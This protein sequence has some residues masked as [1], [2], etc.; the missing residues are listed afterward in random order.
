MI[1]SN[2]PNEKESIFNLHKKEVIKWSIQNNL[3]SAMA[4]YTEYGVKNYTFKMPKLSDPEWDTIL[5]NVSIIS[6]LQGIPIGMKIYNGYAFTTNTTNNFFTTEDT[7]YYTDNSGSNIYHRIDCP[8][9]GNN[10]ITAHKSYLFE[11]ILDESISPAEWRYIKTT[12]K[13]ERGINYPVDYGKLTACYYCMVN[14]NYTQDSLFPEK[15]RA[16][17]TAI[18]K[19]RYLHINVSN[20]LNY[21]P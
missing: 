10:G 19:E 18:A 5:K 13:D 15:K 17:Y 4:S 11:K 7:L 20:E 12:D 3:N 2:N 14:S 1:G 6:F 8:E 9:L 21:T 16:M